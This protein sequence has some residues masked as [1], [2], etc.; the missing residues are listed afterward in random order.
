MYHLVPMNSPFP[1]LS[2]KLTLLAHALGNQDY[3]S[4]VSVKSLVLRR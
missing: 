3:I 2:L 1:K 4:L